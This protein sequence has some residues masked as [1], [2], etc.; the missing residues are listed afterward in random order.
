MNRPDVIILNETWLKDT[1]PDENILPSKQYKIFRVDRSEESHPPDPNDPKKFRRNGGGVLIAVRT[2]LD[3]VSHKIKVKAAA[4][5]LFVQL[6]LKNGSKYIFS[7]CYRVG[8]LGVKHHDAFIGAL[9]T[10]LAKTKPP[11]LFLIGDF[12]LSDADWCENKSSVSLDK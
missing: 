11:K 10:I 12:N 5:T 7:T 4:K 6:T 3:L 2:D 9:R 1:I 8:T